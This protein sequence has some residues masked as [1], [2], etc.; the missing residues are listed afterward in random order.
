MGKNNKGGPNKNNVEERSGY[1]FTNLY[2]GVKERNGIEHG[3]LA[4]EDSTQQLTRLIV[5]VSKLYK[6]NWK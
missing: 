4:V 3:G 1:W 2:S 6:K 5:R